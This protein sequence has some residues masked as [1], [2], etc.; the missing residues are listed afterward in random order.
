MFVLA[1]NN[2]VCA[3]MYTR[4]TYVGVLRRFFYVIDTIIKREKCLMDIRLEIRSFCYI[5]SVFAL[6]NE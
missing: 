6:S 4:S 2:I 5:V 1:M 3:Y